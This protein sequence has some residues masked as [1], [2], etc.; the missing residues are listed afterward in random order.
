MCVLLP[1]LH[2]VWVAWRPRG[3]EYCVTV[4]QHA[5]EARISKTGWVVVG[6]RGERL[7]VGDMSVNVQS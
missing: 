5:V 7:P 6:R 3:V 1:A 2:F 4:V